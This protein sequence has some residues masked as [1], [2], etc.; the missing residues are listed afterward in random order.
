MN[1]EHDSRCKIFVVLFAWLLGALTPDLPG[2]LPLDPACW[3][4]S[5]P[6]GPLQL[7][8][9][10]LYVLV[11][12]LVSRIETEWIMSRKSNFSGSI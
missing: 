5:V 4:T 1:Y 11:K 9:P 3:R 6:S 12:P 10:N 2:T 7:C 8:P